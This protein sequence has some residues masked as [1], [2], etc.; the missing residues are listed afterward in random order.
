MQRLITAAHTDVGIKKK[1]NQDAICLE[2]AESDIGLIALAAI[3]DG[4]GGLADGEKASAIMTET[5]SGWFE[6]SLAASICRSG[7]LI[8]FDQFKDEFD[9]MIKT[10]NDAI[11]KSG[12]GN[13]GTTIC[14]VLLA[15]DRYYT[16]N[17][18]DSRAYHLK[19]GK[20]IQIT[21][22]QTVVQHELDKGFITEADIKT[23]PQRSVL[24][25]CVGASDI[26]FPEYC[27]GNYKSGDMFLVCS[28]GF[29]HEITTEEFESMLNIDSTSDEEYITLLKNLTALNK[30]RGEKDNISS[31]L[32]KPIQTGRFG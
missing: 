5:L 18:G 21:K 22:D 3:C 11:H 10:A 23:H 27:D 16:A 31:I 2:I 29:R 15:C 19:D 28:D 6:N 12:G 25:Q 20:L 32:I 30:K 26:V 24:L 9:F 7:S 8:S 14:A 1:I 4:M 17:V 13:S